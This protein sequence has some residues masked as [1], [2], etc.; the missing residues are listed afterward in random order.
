MRRLFSW[1]ATVT[2]T[3]NGPHLDDTSSKV[4][5]GA[6]L[7]ALEKRHTEVTAW[8]LLAALLTVEDVVDAC[9]A[10]HALDAVK[11]VTFEQLAL[12]PSARFGGRPR[13]KDTSPILRA[14]AAAISAGNA[15]TNVLHL[16]GGVVLAPA[17]LRGLTQA[18]V[19]VRL[20]AL[21]TR[22]GVNPPRSDASLADHEEAVVRVHNDDFTPMEVVTDLLAGVLD[23]PPAEAHAAM[24]SVHQQGHTDVAR[25]PLPEARVV[26]Q[27]LMAG[28]WARGCPLTCTL[29]RAPEVPSDGAP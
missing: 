25:G 22:Y 17:V 12:L 27:A 8:H 1:W 26:A 20:L 28:A 2:P 9:R 19:K 29:Q 21:V 5:K 7:L 11:V 4:L 13:Y 10:C 15:T 3:T 16:L 14:M 6:A 24:M 18:G 23:Q